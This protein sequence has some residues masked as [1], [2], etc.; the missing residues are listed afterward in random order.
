MRSRVKSL[1]MRRH[2]METLVGWINFSL[3][4]ITLPKVVPGV[5]N[6][7]KFLCRQVFLANKRIACLVAV[8]AKLKVAFT[9]FHDHEP[10]Q[11]RNP[12][13]KS[14]KQE[15]GN[16]FTNCRTLDM[17][18]NV[19]Q[20]RDCAYQEGRWC[21]NLEGERLHRAVNQWS[22]VESSLEVHEL[23][24]YALSTGGKHKGWNFPKE[25]F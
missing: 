9:C 21:K 7:W 4:W 14:S 2:L 17:Q 5:G 25:S 19:N 15:I 23:W 16:N 13:L 11:L 12:G 3:L 1:S 22:C 20:A 6:L 18:I 10:W 8:N 24:F